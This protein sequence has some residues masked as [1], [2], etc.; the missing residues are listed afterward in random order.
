MNKKKKRIS[1]FFDGDKNY[2]IIPDT[3]DWVLGKGNDFTICGFWD[4]D[5]KGYNKYNMCSCKNYTK[6]K[7]F[8]HE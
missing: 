7:G 1:K 4:K 6:C 2:L 3:S 5:G 8:K